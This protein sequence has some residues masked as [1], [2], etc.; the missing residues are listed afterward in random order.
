MGR[1][2]VLTLAAGRHAH[3]IGQ[4]EGLT[5][6]S[7][8]PDLHVVVSMGDE[9]LRQGDVPIRSG[10]WSTSTAYLPVSEQGLPLAQARNLAARSATAAGADL[11]IFLDVDCIPSPTLVQ[12]YGEA[13][14]DDRSSWRGQDEPAGSAPALFSGDIAYLPPE[15]ESGYPVDDLAAL[16]TPSPLRPVLAAGQRQIET[17]FELFWSLSFAMSA[18]D[19]ETSGGFCEEYQGYGGEDTDFAQVVNRLGGSLTWVGGA[20]AYHQ[21]HDSVMP[22]VHHLVA[23]VRNANVFYDRWGWWPM[24]GWLQAFATRGLAAR[25]GPE[26]RWAVVE[27]DECFTQ[28]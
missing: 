16:A 3:L 12:E 15:P 17:R 10:S 7:L 13:V 24:D 21:H 1:I 27:P 9:A 23:V 8:V 22:P 19:F 11:L 18:A 25:R 26:H 5:R 4:V 14:R 2:A 6:Q 28:R 20:T